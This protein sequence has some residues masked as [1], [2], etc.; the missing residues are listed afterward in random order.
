LTIRIC[1]SIQPKNATDIQRMLKKAEESHADFV[2]I[3][4]DDL[5]SLRELQSLLEHHKTPLIATDHSRRP[6]ADKRMMIVSAA[7]LGFEYADIDLQTPKL[8]SLITQAKAEGVKCIVSSHDCNK[9]PSVVDLNRI[10]ER[11]VSS[12]ADVFKIVT[13]AKRIEDNLTLLQFIQAAPVRKK[14]VCFAMGELGKTS[15]LLSP[16]FGSFFTFAAM[17]LGGETAPGQMTIQEMRAAYEL[18]KLN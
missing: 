7:K 9:T 1:V 5:T 4:L 11:E 10:L 3:R 12:G 15:R 18:L 13:T 16:I 8:Q 17:D 2:E 6:E 14:P